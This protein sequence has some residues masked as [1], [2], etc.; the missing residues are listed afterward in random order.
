M[1]QPDGVAGL[2]LGLAIFGGLTS[3][4]AGWN[5]AVTNADAPVVFWHMTATH[6]DTALLRQ[7]LF[8]VADRQSGGLPAMP[9]T[10]IAPQDGIVAWLLRDFTHADFID[11]VGDAAGD[12]VV[13]LPGSVQQPELGLEL[14]RAGFRDHA[15][16]G[17]RQ[18]DV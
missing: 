4:G 9:V 15:D 16:V 10:V 18:H 8:D 13:L 11:N 3:L 12:E 5:A 2:G 1:G 17:Q 6:G 14:R 7:T